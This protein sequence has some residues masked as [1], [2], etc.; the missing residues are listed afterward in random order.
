MARYRTKDEVD[1]QWNRIRRRLTRE[2]DTQIADW[3]E[4]ALNSLLSHA[5]EEHVK[6]LGNGDVLEVEPDYKPWVAQ[7][8]TEAVNVGVERAE[9]DESPVS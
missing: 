6:A 5:W 1:L 9:L 4:E 7:A 8:L 3:R 2:L